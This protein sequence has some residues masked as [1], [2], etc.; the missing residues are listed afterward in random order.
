MTSIPKISSLYETSLASAMSSSA[1]SFS[2][3][4]GTDRDGNALSGLYG[5]IIAEG[6]ADEEFVVGT[7]SGTTVTIS[8]RGCD[9][10]DPET[11]VAANKKA[12][13]RGDSVKITDYPILAYLRNIL[14]AETN[15]TLPNP[16]RYAAGVTPSNNSDLADKEYVDGVAVAGASDANETTKGI[17]EEATQVEIEAGTA[18]GGTGAKLILTPAKFGAKLYYGYAADAGAADAYAI[19]LSPAPT[20]YTTGMVIVFKAN[21]INTG[22]ATINVNSLGAKD[23]RRNNGLVLANG[24]IQASQFNTIVYNGTYFELQSPIGKPQV[25]TSGEEIYAASSGG[26]DTYAITLAPIPTAYTTGMVVR[27]KADVAN[28]GAATLNVN[29]LGAKTIKK[30]VTDDLD[31]NDILANQVITVIYDGTNFLMMNTPAT[32][33][34]GITTPIT[35]SHAHKRTKFTATRVADTADGAV[36]Y[37]HGLGAIPN[38]V[39]IFYV[40]GDSDSTLNGTG[41]GVYDRVAGTQANVNHQSIN[42]NNQLHTDKAVYYE[43]S[44]GTESGVVTVDATN[45]TITWTKAATP[46]AT[47]IRMIIETEI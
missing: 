29:S 43:D 5:F 35:N 25:S 34:A 37:A 16:L 47:N 42:A 40:W 39:R 22:A 23:I 19:T 15:Y 27:F 1:T 36:T 6:S 31:T 33:T 11:E 12:H 44:G 46:A 13:R 14:N 4:S 28:T 17:V 7:I 8:K 21:T 24:D 9:A 10:D 2:V 3:V 45:V 41:F 18:T 26:T 20:A 38:T 32:L 30:N